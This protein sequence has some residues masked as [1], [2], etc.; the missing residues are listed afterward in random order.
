MEITATISLLGAVTF[1]VLGSGGDHLRG[2]AM[3]VAAVPGR[4]ASALARFGFTIAGVFSSSSTPR[5]SR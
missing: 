5:T 2:F 1:D 3:E 4:A